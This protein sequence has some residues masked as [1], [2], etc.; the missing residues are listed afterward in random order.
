MKKCLGIYLF[1]Y[2]L[3]LC[4]P[5]FKGDDRHI[6]LFILIEILLVIIYQSIEVYLFMLWLLE[7]TESTHH[8]I[9]GL[10]LLQIVTPVPTLTKKI[11]TNITKHKQ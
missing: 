7:G 11:Q 9:Y 1:H 5:T 2:L 6:H 3:I 10:N 4:W 8:S